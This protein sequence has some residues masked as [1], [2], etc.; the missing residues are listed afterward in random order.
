MNNKL[1]NLIKEEIKYLSEDIQ[2]NATL[3]KPLIKIELSKYNEQQ[4]PSSLPQ[5]GETSI[6]IIKSENKYNI[7]KIKAARNDLKDY[8]ISRIN[9]ENFECNKENC[10]YIGRSDDIKNRLKQHLFLERKTTYA[11]RLKQLLKQGKITIEVYNF[12]YIEKNQNREIQ[13][14]EDLLWRHYQPL[15]GRQGAK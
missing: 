9:E 2:P 14:Y 1:K 13:I 15:L 5:K 3:I 6:Y 7:A 12:G 8:E 10:L 11:M 4:I